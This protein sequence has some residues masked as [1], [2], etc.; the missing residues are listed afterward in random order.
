LD[1]NEITDQGIKE[2]VDLNNLFYINLT[3][4]AVSKKG[5]EQLMN[6]KAL[7][8]VYLYQTGLNQTD[9]S[10]LKD[11]WKNIKIYGADTMI[12]CHPIPYFKK[13]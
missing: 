10:A 9:I 6:N 4:T 5:I 3:F 8:S 7:E 13:G 11:K 12:K 2:L 1:E